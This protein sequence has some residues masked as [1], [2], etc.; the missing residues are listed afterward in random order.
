MYNSEYKYK[1]YPEDNNKFLVI[2]TKNCDNPF[3]LLNSDKIYNFEC[4]ISDSLEFKSLI[5]SEKIIYPFDYIKWSIVNFSNYVDSVSF[6][7]DTKNDCNNNAYQYFTL[8]SESDSYPLA[9][10]LIDEPEFAVLPKSIGLPS[11]KWSRL[12]AFGTLCECGQVMFQCT[13]VDKIKL[14]AIKINNIDFLKL[15]N[16]DSN[17]RLN[18]LLNSFDIYSYN[19]RTSDLNN[20]DPSLLN[21][22]D[23]EFYESELANPLCHAKMFTKLFKKSRNIVE[24]IVLKYYRFVNL[25]IRLAEKENSYNYLSSSNCCYTNR[26]LLF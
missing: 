23:C 20:L 5:N 1:L 8:K 18:F 11:V 14:Q 16:C 13:N 9:E 3:L 4:I 12:A 7:D 2:P 17:I 10:R 15:F 19:K 26:Y 21:N 24:I 6:H 25:S 22:L